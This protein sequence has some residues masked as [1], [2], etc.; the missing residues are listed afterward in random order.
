[1]L[2]TCEDTDIFPLE[3]TKIIAVE[4]KEQLKLNGVLCS[5]IYKLKILWVICQKYIY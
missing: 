1:M 5:L 4:L 3:N 2:K